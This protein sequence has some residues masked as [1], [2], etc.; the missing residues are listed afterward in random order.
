MTIDAVRDEVELSLNRLRPLFIDGAELTFVM[1]VPEHSERYMIISNDDIGDVADL[2]Y[3][4]SPKGTE[5]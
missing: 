5:Q 4:H 3:L 1:R 2:L